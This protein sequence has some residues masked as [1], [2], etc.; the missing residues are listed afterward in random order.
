M[1]SSDFPLL[2][3]P[4]ISWPLTRIYYPSNPS[5][6]PQSDTFQT[7]SVILTQILHFTYVSIH[8][9]YSANALAL[10]CTA[11][12]CVRAG[13]N[14]PFHTFSSG[15]ALPAHLS[16][17]I[18]D[19]NALWLSKST[20]CNWKNLKRNFPPTPA[21]LMRPQ[22]LWMDTPILRDRFLL[23]M[24]ELV[25]QELARDIAFN[26]GIICWA[27]NGGKIIEIGNV[28]VYTGAPWDIR[29]WEVLVRAQVVANRCAR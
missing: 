9:A 17:R 5:M 11:E 13:Y 1:S 24:H 23:P 27:P 18:N 7:S 2:Q 15:P 10:G 25:G 8:I 20:A 3:S 21:Q 14:S 28:A 19:S 29:K 26:D 4:S 22:N 16:H 12:L 6:I